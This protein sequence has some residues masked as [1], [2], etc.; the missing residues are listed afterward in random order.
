MFDRR[1]CVP[2]TFNNGGR[3]LMRLGHFLRCNR[4]EPHTFFFLLVRLFY[5]YHLA[6]FSVLFH[7]KVWRTYFH[8]H[9]YWQWM[10]LFSTAH[11]IPIPGQ[12]M[13]CYN[14]PNSKVQNDR[15][16]VSKQVWWFFFQ[17]TFRNYF[18]VFNRFCQ[19]LFHFIFFFNLPSRIALLLLNSLQKS[20][21]W[22]L[23]PARMAL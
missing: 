22:R 14:K 11:G 21:R 7:A 1:I 3:D 15:I 12:Q 6:N 10:N 2:N 19:P 8:Y 9:L 18:Y 4:L 17:I 20:W 23:I 16:V 5:Q 13:N